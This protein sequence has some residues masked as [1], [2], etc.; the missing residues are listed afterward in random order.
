L[1]AIC[2]EPTLSET[3]TKSFPAQMNTRKKRSGQP[4]RR[5]VPQLFSPEP[6]ENLKAWVQKTFPAKPTM[7]PEE[8]I[9]LW[10]SDG[11]KNISAINAKPPALPSKSYPQEHY[12]DPRSGNGYR[13]TLQQVAETVAGISAI[14]AKTP[15]LPSK[16]YP[17]EH[18]EDP[19][20]G[21][22]Y[23]V[24]VQQIAETVAAA[25]AAALYNEQPR[26]GPGHLLPTKLNQ[27]QEPGQIHDVDAQTPRAVQPDACP[28]GNTGEAG[29]IKLPGASPDSGGAGMQSNK[30]SAESRLWTM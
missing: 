4:G 23:R 19:C 20:S 10:L 25:V 21:N 7:Q 27:S 5:Q 22:G 6:A 11:T 26:P 3:W 30:T 8:A 24:T 16:S 15:A 29:V 13:V 2:V 12:E 17:Q 1:Q 18:S 14:N 9:R 28:A